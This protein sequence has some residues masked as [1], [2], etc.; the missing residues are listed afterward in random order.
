MV[1]DEPDGV[2]GGRG[3]GGGENEVRGDGT[4]GAV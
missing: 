1:V 2:F 4:G 3:R